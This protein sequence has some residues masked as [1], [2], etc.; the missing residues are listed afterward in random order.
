MQRLLGI[1]VIRCTSVATFSTV[2]PG[3]NFETDLY[4]FRSYSRIFLI[5]KLCRDRQSVIT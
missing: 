1:A 2:L 3:L 5:S 4:C